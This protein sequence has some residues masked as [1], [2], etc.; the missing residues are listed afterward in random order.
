MIRKILFL[1]VGAILIS[2]CKDDRINIWVREYSD[3]V[4]EN[5]GQIQDYIKSHYYD[6]STGKL[7]TIGDKTGVTPLAQIMQKKVI[8]VKD[9]HNKYIDHNL[10]YYIIDEGDGKKINVAD[11]VFLEFRGYTLDD[12][13]FD[14]TIGYTKNNKIDLLGKA[15]GEGAVVGFREGLTLIKDSKGEITQGEKGEIIMP[16]TGGKIIMIMPSGLAYFN[17]KSF[18]GNAY[19]S[20]IFIVNAIKATQMDHD[21][22]GKLSQ[23][24]I[25]HDPNTG[26]IEYNDCNEN[27]IPDYLEVTKCY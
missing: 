6:Q 25:K 1:A 19:A 11:E 3:V 17:K 2:S 7:E 18:Q 21:R 24:E 5:E 10:Y 26:I 4:K 12:K 22:D 20:L 23:D 16:N 8:K 13:E 27:G 15:V 9:I 14:S